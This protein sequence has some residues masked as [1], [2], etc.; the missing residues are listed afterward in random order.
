MGFA[1]AAKALS[2]GDRQP[3]ERGIVPSGGVREG[4]I[5]SVPMPWEAVTSAPSVDDK[6]AAEQPGTIIDLREANHDRTVAP[7]RARRGRRSGGR[8]RAHPVCDRARGRSGRRPADRKSTRLN[9]SHVK[10]SYA[11][12]CLKKKKKKEIHSYYQNKKTREPEQK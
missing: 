1:Q 4:P 8:N 5:G 3:T 2:S 11:D 9:S 7:P 12:F 10:I 6:A